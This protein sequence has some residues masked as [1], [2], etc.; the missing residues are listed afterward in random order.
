[1][2]S[3]TPDDD[4]HPRVCA[5]HISGQML[6]AEMILRPAARAVVEVGLEAV[7]LGGSGLSPCLDSYSIRPW[8]SDRAKEGPPLRL[9]DRVWA[10]RLRLFLRDRASKTKPPNPFLLDIQINSRSDLIRGI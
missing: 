2:S 1:M 5:A 4:G 3:G 9:S 7:P 6:E 10:K 8:P